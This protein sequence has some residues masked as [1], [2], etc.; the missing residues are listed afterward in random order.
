VFPTPVPNGQE[1]WIRW[2]D[3][4]DAGNDH[5]LAIDDLSITAIAP[6]ETSVSDSGGNL[7]ITDGNGG[8]SNDNL[9]L[10]LNGGNVRVNDPGNTL[11][12]GAGATQVNANTCDVPFAS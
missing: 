3:V 5:G 12:C 9:T 6:P 1:I 11:T 8:N 4:N 2:E 7:I 10:S